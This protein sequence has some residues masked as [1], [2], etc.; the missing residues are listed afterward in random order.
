[1]TTRSRR[2]PRWR[3]R[4]ALTGTIA[5]A[6]AL[7][8]AIP[9]WGHAS[10]PTAAAF[11]F[12][13]NQA[14]GT[15]A[16][17]AAP[18]YVPG[19]YVTITARVPFEQKV[20]FNG[21]D[22]TTVDIKVIVP[23][24]WTN[25][26]CGPARAQVNDASTNN[27][28]QPGREVLGWTCEVVTELAHQ[29]I[30]W[31]GPQVKAPKTAADSAQFFTF[32]VTAP[33]PATQTT[34]NGK[35]GTEGFIVDQVYPSGRVVRWVPDASFTGTPPVGAEVEVATGLARTV[36]AEGTVFTPLSPQRLLDSRTAT[37]GWTG[38]L[39]SAAPQNL[40]VAGAG[41]PVP[42]NAEAVVLNVTATESTADS[43]LTVY[44]AG[45]TA[46][47]A[48]NLN[49]VV[50][51]TIPNLVVAKVGTNGQISF[52]VGQGTVHVV[53]DVVGYF[54][55]GAGDRYNAVAPSRL[56]DSRTATG[57]WAST[58]LGEGQTK[59][60]KVQGAGGVSATATA[61]VLNVTATNATT[62]SFLTV[63][64][65]GE[66]VPTASSLNFTAGQTI[67]NLVIVKVGAAGEVAVTNHA[68]TVDVVADVVGYFDATGDTFHSVVPGRV[69][70][71]RNATAPAVAT[72]LGADTPKAVAITGL[73]GVRADA[74]AVFANVTVTEPTADSFLTAYPNGTTA[75]TASNLNY[76]AAQTIPNLVA[77]GVGSGG[78]V[79]LVNHAGTTHVVVDV[80]GYF[81][82]SVAI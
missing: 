45:A 36:G 55:A 6:G 72:P 69:L 78:S 61:V 58:P 5:V 1:M 20:P 11:G 42:A 21:A 8:S 32:S 7:T 74:S 30:H 62:G 18:P 29:V 57:G 38:A 70:D 16:P 67:P 19:E 24:G 9:S 31:S 23:A 37:G 14:G 4:L 71:T 35:N 49:F 66:A 34:Y 52:A 12:L 77:V 80:V 33:I 22:D 25:P 76:S 2:A 56:L 54:A 40:T 43:F 50:G 41:L 17:G 13:P 79:A 15:G 44:P 27:T 39:A 3:A 60:L 65:A 51:Q 46:P 26:S 48:S 64:P 81:A 73:A 68:G 82:P 53:A 75:P 59:T 10:F 63:S 47:T 28:N